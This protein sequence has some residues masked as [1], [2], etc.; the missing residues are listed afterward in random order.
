MDTTPGEAPEETGPFPLRSQLPRQDLA[1]GAQGDCGSRLRTSCFKLEACL[2]EA[3]DDWLH[4]GRKAAIQRLYHDV[5]H[6]PLLGDAAL[7]KSLLHAMLQTVAGQHGIRFSLR[8]DVVFSN[9]THVAF[10]MA[11]EGLARV[12]SDSSLLEEHE[13]ELKH[14]AQKFGGDLRIERPR[15]TCL[16]LNSRLR[17]PIGRVSTEL[18]SEL[19]HGLQILI[20]DDDSMSRMLAATLLR[21]L[22][23]QVVT[24]S[25]GQEALELA[26]R[27]VFDLVF[28]DIEMP[29]MDGVMTCRALRLIAGWERV[30]I[31]A[32]TSH[33]QGEQHAYCLE[34]GMW[35]V[36]VKPLDKS[37]LYALARRYL[38]GQ[39][40]HEHLGPSV[41]SGSTMHTEGQDSDES[42][43]VQAE[44]L[45]DAFG[46]TREVLELCVTVFS[47]RY[48]VLLDE[49]EL[50][51]VQANVGLVTRQ[52]HEL[53]GMLSNLWLPSLSRV[54][55]DLENQC[56]RGEGEGS[57]ERVQLLR[58][59]IPLAIEELQ[60]IVSNWPLLSEIPS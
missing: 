2:E 14:L 25:H 59:S 48:P 21:N 7:L 16:R 23:A 54:S 3:L 50:G 19:L 26:K 60:K 51:I 35:E 8:R 39:G 18:R 45:Y 13:I 1:S 5:F 22:E 29:G 55:A 57:L 10:V 9:E 52:A 37:T 40:A 49:M 33:E 32:L 42:H 11:V 47:R 17:F 28:L 34:Q 38:L 12:E 56:R 30:P 36:L 46:E 20:V 31:F 44:A 43:Y 4:S 24:V 6:D 58:T 53:K 15:A 41:R 27:Q